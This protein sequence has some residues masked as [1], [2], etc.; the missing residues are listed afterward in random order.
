MATALDEE[1]KQQQLANQTQMYVQGAQAAAAARP[2]APAPSQPTEPLPPAGAAPKQGE[3]ARQMGEVG[4]F[5]KDMAAGALK[6]IVSAP[7]YGFNSAEAPR[8]PAAAS[9]TSGAPNRPAPGPTFSVGQGAR[10]ANSI[11]A[12]KADAPG[13]MSAVPTVSAAA[14][15][16]TAVPAGFT[17]V[18]ADIYRKGNMF[19]DAAGM[20]NTGFESRGAVSPQ[21]MAAAEGLAKRYAGNPQYAAEVATADAINARAPAGSTGGFGLLDA[22]RIAARNA[23]IGG[24]AM[25]KQPGESRSDYATR[26]GAMTAQRGQEVD[27]RGNIRSNETSMRNT[28]VTSATSR[29]NTL[30]GETGANVRAGMSA[31]IQRGELATKQVAAG[32]SA[33]AAADLEKARTA[34]LSAKTPEA[35]ATAAKQLQVLSGNAPGD[36]PRFAYA[37]GG[38]VYDEKVGALV[39]QPGVIY[40]Q[41]TGQAVTPRAGGAGS[42]AAPASPPPNHIAALK[43]NPALAAQFNQQYGAG[44]AEAILGKK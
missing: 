13:K 35:Q 25:A 28:D 2:P 34:F 20:S 43:G 11:D 19:T 10:Q 4:G 37:P 22:N 8:P 17:Q 9:T 44:A 15:A 16:P 12:A 38:Q 23:S 33:R 3:Y 27:E 41:Y 14:P 26:I 36:R 1:R 39:N 42:S 18:G 31:D 7:G 5:F 21:N 32:F 40:D 29:A 30:A 24:G 6:T